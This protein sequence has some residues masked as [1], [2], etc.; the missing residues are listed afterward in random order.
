MTTLAF[1]LRARTFRSLRRHR[2]YRIFFTGQLVSLAGTW[3]QNVALAWLVIELSG[4]ALAIGALAFWRFVPF[5]VFGLVAGVMADR[6]ESRKLVMATQAA[7]MVIS[8]ALAV[9][10][11]TGTATL[12]VVY[13]LAALGGVALAFD[14]PGRQSLTFQMVGPRE[15]P[16]AVALN[17]GLFNGSRVIGPAIAGLVIAAVGTGLCFVVNAVSFLAVLT[18]LLLVREEELVQVEKDRGATVLGGIRRAAGFAWRD[19]Q[20]RL[21]L[22]VVTV[23]ATVG[24]NF[25]VLVPLLA[26]DTLHV[27]PEGFGFLSA[28]FGLGALVGALAAATFRDASWRL[29]A[30]GTASFGVLA[31]LLAPVQNAYLAGVLL[32]GIGVSFTLFTANANALVQLAAPDY[33]RGRLIGL[34]LFA[35]LGLAPVGGLF[36]GWLAE[37]GGTSLAFAVA[38]LTSLVT[39]AVAQTWRVRATTPALSHAR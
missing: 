28:A 21:I 24:F 14:A 19:P 8:I 12:P 32:V 6:F 34:Y 35:F 1:A 4:S 23:V 39:I 29:F 26:A 31:L 10:T 7:A 18:A 16:N 5:M 30:I 3:M 11:L 17:S 22:G 25:H 9:V 27:G 20:L 37:V 15:L 2:N 38:G 13:V 33:L 36:S